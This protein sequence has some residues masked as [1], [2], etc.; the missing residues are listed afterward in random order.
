MAS[1]LIRRA[2]TIVSRRFSR[3]LV[4]TPR[5]G[6]HDLRHSAA[7][8]LIAEG[9]DLKRVSDFMGHSSIKITAD[10]YGHLIEKTRQETASK[11]EVKL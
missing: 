8:R 5:S 10:V 2:C 6:F 1:R 9:E 7:S 4:L 3:W 11:L